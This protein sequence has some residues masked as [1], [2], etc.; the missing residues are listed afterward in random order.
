LAT[1]VAGARAD[2][3]GVRCRAGSVAVRIANLVR[4]EEACRSDD[5]F[6]VG[7]TGAVAIPEIGHVAAAFDDSRVVALA[8]PTVVEVGAGVVD[9]AGASDGDARAP[10]AF[11][12]VGAGRVLVRSGNADTVGLTETRE[13][14]ERL[15]ALPWA[16]VIGAAVTFLG[17]SVLA[18]V[19]ADAG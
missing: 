8:T 4:G 15:T 17:G 7:A 19:A 11:G 9:D 14:P 2:R 1:Q 10:R 5:A 16:G 18:V 3:V 6:E 13:V 12:I